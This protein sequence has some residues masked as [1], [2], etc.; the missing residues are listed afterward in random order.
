MARTGAGE[1][2]VVASYDLSLPI[3]SKNLWEA[4]MFMETTTIANDVVLKGKLY[5]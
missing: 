5:K 1:N 3:K 2:L 4:P